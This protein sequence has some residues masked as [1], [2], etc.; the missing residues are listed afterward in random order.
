MFSNVDV[1]TEDK[2]NE[3]RMKLKNMTM[4][5]HIIALQEIRPKHHRYERVL[6]EYALDG[7]EIAGKNINLSDEGR[8][9]LMYLRKGMKYNIV[10][11]T[12][13]YCEYLCVEV[14]GN[15]DNLLVTSLY[16]SPS[17]NMMG[18][19]ENLL[20]LMQEI[21]DLNTRYKV[22]VGDFNFPNINWN[23]YTTDTDTDSMS[24]K[25]IEKIR[26][27]Y[28]T[29]HISDITRFR[30]F[31]KGNILDLLF[32]NDDSIVEKVWMDSPLGKSDHSCI[33]FHCDIQEQEDVGKK[34]I[35][36]Y[37]KA[38]YA[39]MRKKLNI[40]WKNFLDEEGTIDEKWNKFSRKLKQ[41]INEYIPKKELN[42]KETTRKI[43]NDK[44]PMN[45]KLWSKIK[46][47]QRLWEKLKH[48]K[49]SASSNAEMGDAEKLRY[50][51]V[52]TEYKRTNNQVRWE[53][54]NF[55]KIKERQIAKNV[56]TNP[57]V[58]WKYVQ[59]KTRTKSKIPDMYKD[60]EN[61]IK[62][63]NDKEKAD[64]LSKQFSDVFISEPGGEIP[65]C[66][67]RRVE[68]LQHLNIT[69]EKIKK[70]IRKL[71][72]YKS[73]GPDEIHP[74]VI[75]ELVEEVCEPLHI[76]FEYSFQMH[77]L[78]GD[79]RIANITAIYKKGD[80]S[81]PGNYRP[82][83]LTSVICKIMETLVRDDIMLHLKKWKLISR[84]QYGF[85]T[86][87]STVL[88]LLKVMDKWTATL[89]EG[90]ALDVVYCDFMKAFDRVPHRRL[91]AKV[92]SYGI[93]ESYVSWI[94]S[95]L[96]N[97]RQRVMVNGEV[98]EW[99]DVLS[100]V[101]Q[102]SVLGPLLFVIFINDLPEAVSGDSE[103]FLYA[104]DTKIFRQIKTD[105]DCSKLQEDLDAMRKWTEKWLLNFHPSKCKY[106]RIG[107]SDVTQFGY[108]MYE[109]LEECTVEKDIGVII[110][111]RLAFSDH[112]A[113]KINKAN[114]IVGI[115]RRTFISL[116][117]EVFKHLYTALVRP[118]LEYAN[119][120]WCPRL[121][122]DIE[123]VEN[124]Q[125]RATKLVPNLNALSYEERL[126]KLELPTLAY[127]R[128]RGDMIE[129][130]KILSGKYD[131][132]CSEDIIQLREES[133]TRG[134]PKKIYKR[135]TRLNIRKYSFSNR[136]VDN[137]N[138]LPDLVIE[139]DTVEKFE[140]NLDKVWLSQ[141]QKY[142]YKVPIKYKQPSHQNRQTFE[143]ENTALETQA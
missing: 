46:R 96:E 112:L 45:R 42:T 97:R 80:K 106:M 113:E 92:S 132:E 74:R 37:E 32:S 51:Q 83:S 122:K 129:T 36:L 41:V 123:A 125:R 3:L 65:A 66:Q 57:K 102:G 138:E 8:G 90:L 114:K 75:K 121:V 28:L 68:T 52:E 34:Y 26:D 118:H 54:R 79:W 35:Y 98:S 58:F 56:R 72:K 85:V 38:D 81:D 86:G 39:A 43:M 73:P 127:R 18:N 139:S 12:T 119:Q 78:P 25:F 7:Y 105:N 1:Y 82:V 87:R 137:W 104:D 142:N 101:P 24:Y 6:S 2:I 55:I 120:V 109:D 20:L 27:C 11:L 16:R 140:R 21:S 135:R 88:Q 70:T 31:C 44:L 134:H 5:P 29:Q 4:P 23:N 50:K 103:M 33:L 62:T 116:D 131:E 100:G 126:K 76:L 15:V 14:K 143:R 59:S 84:R 111:N 130:Y 19:E 117:M 10:N 110:D 71:K 61:N 17:N 47:K 40:N 13:N 64:V 89:D 67:R 63:V 48:M 60:K 53:T 9:L 136:I 95:F 91:L 99:R 77:Q 115:I 108:K 133:A 128:S 49:Q 22:I 124:V 94:R 107:R 30:G 69:D 93:G 141:E